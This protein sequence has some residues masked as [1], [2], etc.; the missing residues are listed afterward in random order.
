M[1]NFIT[2][3]M[4]KK[5][6]IKLV[7]L[8]ISLTNILFS[9]ISDVQEK[10]MKYDKEHTCYICNAI[11]TRIESLAE[12]CL[13]A[14]AIDKPYQC[15]ECKETFASKRTCRFHITNTHEKSEYL[16]LISSQFVC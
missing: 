3:G 1:L 4:L 8:S 12:H 16:C 13:L 2:I 9:E 11:F 10:T 6:I 7:M 5:Y 14:H 15:P